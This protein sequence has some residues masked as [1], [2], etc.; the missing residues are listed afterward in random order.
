MEH[1]I[2][3]SSNRARGR[4]NTAHDIFTT[5]ATG[6]NMSGG[7]CAELSQSCN[8]P[9][10]WPSASI[11]VDRSAQSNAY[12]ISSQLLKLE[13]ISTPNLDGSGFHY[14]SVRRPG[15]ADSTIYTFCST[16]SFMCQAATCEILPDI[17][18]PPSC[19]WSRYHLGDVVSVT[20]GD[21][22][23]AYGAFHQ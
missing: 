2:P 11:R 4:R 18:K 13:L 19:N 21:K 6:Y 5:T 12:A 10:T 9:G 17:Q 3:I 15:Q 1:L 20:R 7:Y 8:L 16:F 23:W 14:A 22:T